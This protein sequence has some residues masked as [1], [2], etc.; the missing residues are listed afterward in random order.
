M[1]K[2]K[3]KVNIR[4]PFIILSTRVQLP[5]VLLPICICTELLFELHRLP[6]GKDVIVLWYQHVPKVT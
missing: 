5:C 1:L 6:D 4:I 3:E 2:V